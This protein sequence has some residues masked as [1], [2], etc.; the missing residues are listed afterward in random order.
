MSNTL[1]YIHTVMLHK[2][3]LVCLIPSNLGQQDRA[4]FP[5]MTSLLLSDS[6]Q[7]NYVISQLK[8]GF[9]SVFLTVGKQT[10]E[11]AAVAK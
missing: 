6:N 8:L 7:P 4:A 5:H 2:D 10:E 11:S 3:V 9:F 1:Q